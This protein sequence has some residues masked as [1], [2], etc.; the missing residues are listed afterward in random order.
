MPYTRVAIAQI[1]HDLVERSIP[2]TLGEM[3]PV[4]ETQN[5]KVQTLLKRLKEYMDELEKETKRVAQAQAFSHFEAVISFCGT[6]SRHV[7]ILIFPDSLP[8]A[9]RSRISH[10]RDHHGITMIIAGAGHVFPPSA[11]D[12]QGGIPVILPDHEVYV[13]IRRW[14]ELAIEPESPEHGP[15]HMLVAISD[16]KTIGR[17]TPDLEAL[18]LEFH[19]R[20]EIPVAVSNAGGHSRFFI[21][22][23]EN[24][25]IGG[26]LAD[27][28]PLGSL[29]Y[30]TPPGDS[31]VNILD[32][33]LMQRQGPENLPARCVTVAPLISEKDFPDYCRYLHEF[34]NPDEDMERRI[35]NTRSQIVRQATLEKIATQREEANHETFE[36]KIRQVDEACSLR[37][38]FDELQSYA[39]SSDILRLVDAV[40]VP[41]PEN[42]IYMI[43]NSIGD[44]LTELSEHL[45]RVDRALVKK[46]MRKLERLQEL[47]GPTSASNPRV[48]NIMEREK[49]HLSLIYELLSF[50]S[51][52]DSILYDI[53][54]LDEP[55]D[56]WFSID[57]ILSDLDGSGKVEG[58]EIADLEELFL[59][60]RAGEHK[61]RRKKHH[62]SDFEAKPN[63]L[64]KGEDISI[65]EIA[66][67]ITRVEKADLRDLIKYFSDKGNEGDILESLMKLSPKLATVERQLRM[68]QALERLNRNLPVPD[69]FL[70]LR[71]GGRLLMRNL[72]GKRGLA[73]HLVCQDSF[74]EVL[75]GLLMELEVAYTFLRLRYRKKLLELAQLTAR[76]RHECLKERL[77]DI[78]RDGPRLSETLDRLLTDPQ[79]NWEE[80]PEIFA[81]M[82]NLLEAKQ[83]AG[84]LTLLKMLRA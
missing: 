36:R 55:D 83:E 24:D 33:N 75:R 31:A 76:K 62:L 81:M 63:K 48:S 79:E 41:H 53:D 46:T 13:L 50:E 59:L 51:V 57:S 23:G 84:I 18:T 29:V 52:L 9:W 49:R 5:P 60:R 30:R 3:L 7:D 68:Q 71:R 54:K 20:F 21:R 27:A 67:Q 12:L 78:R 38:G 37:S 44:T 39:D 22:H 1:P 77:Q 19:A 34:K 26:K 82:W 10:L 8:N 6:G 80:L 40:V 66:H 11:G 42:Y 28:Q 4:V 69:S 45:P 2:E 73:L 72:L 74:E 47:H 43:L 14:A 65:K 17:T 61:A 70:Q 56:L 35:L 64:D 16:S 32:L 58:S 25:P 15:P